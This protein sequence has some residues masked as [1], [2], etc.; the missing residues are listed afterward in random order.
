[1]I[2]EPHGLLT[3]AVHIYIVCRYVCQLLPL[4]VSLSLSMYVYVYVCRYASI[5]RGNALWKNN[6]PVSTCRVINLCSLHRSFLRDVSA[7]VLLLVAV[8]CIVLRLSFVSCIVLR[9]SAVGFVVLGLSDASSFVLYL[10][11]VA[12]DDRFVF[13]GCGE[14]DLSRSSWPSYALTCNRLSR[15]CGGIGVSLP[16]STASLLLLSLLLR[17]TGIS[18]SSLG[19]DLWPV[20]SVNWSRCWL[21]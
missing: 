19:C 14:G 12:A 15:V 2:G 11:F 9:L 17:Y 20:V 18:L 4:S 13:I 7:W 6:K 5:I 10:S 21:P 16:R 3:R 8:S 1:M